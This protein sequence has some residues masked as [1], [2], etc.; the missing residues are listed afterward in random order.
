MAKIDGRNAS[1]ISRGAQRLESGIT[2]LAE[3]I[4]ANTPGE[5]R[6]ALRV[7]GAYVV[8]ATEKSREPVHIL[9]NQALCL[10]AQGAKSIVLGSEIY[11]YDSTRMLVT[12]VDL[13]VA[14]QVTLASQSEPYLSLRLDLDPARI[15]ELGLRVFPKGPPAV[16][17]RRGVYVTP[18]IPEIVAA[19]TR[20]VELAAE[21]AE[22]ELLASLVID[23]ILIRLLRS[24]IGVR[25]AQIGF[26]ETHTH[27]IS[28]VITWLRSNFANPM[29]VE[30]LADLANMSVSSFHHNF[31]AVTSMS[32]LQYQKALRLQEARR[33]MLTTSMDAGMASWQV[34][35]LSP[36]QFSREYSR[37]F[38]SSPVRDI[39]ALRERGV[40][41]PGESRSRV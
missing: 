32:P 41:P 5:G 39:S 2:R 19:A 34:G 14:G 9:H 12:T 11:R 28:K 21:P 35:Y 33:L 17:E 26:V 23:E 27:G 40:L 15:A 13:P 25:V 7:P 38:G 10:I 24:P 37:F 4:A 8:R 1:P 16:D 3:L 22:A 30:D 20:L 31:K 29:K 18:V 6:S 36:S